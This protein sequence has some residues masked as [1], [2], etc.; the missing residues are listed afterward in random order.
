MSNT[1]CSEDA[2]SFPQAEPSEE[3]L[4]HTMSDEGCEVC[5]SLRLPEPVFLETTYA[6]LRRAAAD[7]CGLCELLQRV[8]ETACTGRDVLI[9]DTDIVNVG[10]S[11]GASNGCAATLTVS[12]DCKSTLSDTRTTA[13]FRHLFSTAPGRAYIAYEYTRSGRIGC[14]L[15]DRRGQLPLAFH[16]F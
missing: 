9:R 5:R 7:G 13:Y 1:A 4:A 10:R 15:T 2:A 8:S 11:S 3:E 6:E 16:D 12:Q 14:S